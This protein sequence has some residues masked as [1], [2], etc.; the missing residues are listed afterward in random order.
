MEVTPPSARSTKIYPGRELFGRLFP[1]T[2]RETGKSPG[3]V[4]ALKGFRR[5]SKSASRKGV[6]V[7]ALT[8]A[9][10]VMAIYVATG[11]GEY[12]VAHIAE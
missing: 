3:A 7:R 6:Q 10:S 1:D 12:V 11:R 5:V 8:P 2:N 9:P 4:E